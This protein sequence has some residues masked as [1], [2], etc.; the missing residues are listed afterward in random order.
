MPPSTPPDDMPFACL[1][2]YEVKGWLGGGRFGDVYL[3]LDPLTQREVAVKVVR[4]QGDATPYLEEVQNLAR[5]DHPAIV[6][7]Y[8]V[9][10]IK[11]RLLIV[12][13]VVKGESLREVLSKGRMEKGKTLETSTQLLEALDHAHERGVVH[14]DIKPE[15]IMI[16]PEVRV[17]VLDFGLS[18]LAQEDLSMSMGGTPAYMAPENWKG[19]FTPASDQWSAA[20]V[21][22]E[23]LTGINP[24]LGNTL[25]EAREKTIRGLR[26]ENLLSL[27]PQELAHAILRALSPKPEERYPSCRAFMEELLG[28]EK[29]GLTLVVRPLGKHKGLPPLTGEQ[30]Q[31]VEDPSPRILVTGGPGT[32]KT[33]LLLARAIRLLKEGEAPESI[34]LFTF[35]FRSWREMETRLEEAIGGDYRAIWLGNFYQ[36][37]LRIVSRFGHLFSL[38]TE[39]TLALPPQQERLVEEAAVKAGGEKAF[40]EI[41]KVYRRARVQGAPWV[42]MVSQA[43]GKWREMLEAFEEHYLRLVRE[44]NTLG[45]ED[46][47]YFALRLL[48]KEEV[49]SFYWERLRHVLVDEVQ[50][51]NG[52]QI[53]LVRVLAQGGSLFLVGD[54]DQSIYQWRG[55]QPSYLKEVKKQGFV[56]HG[57]TQT[58]RLPPEFREMAISLITKNRDRLPKLYWTYREEDKA[59]LFIQPLKTPREEAEYVADMIEILRMKRSYSYS[60]FAI[61]YR[62]K[63]RGRLMEQV[64]KKRKIPFTQEGGRAILDRE[65]VKALLDLLAFLARG[66]G[67]ILKKRVLK[68][69]SPLVGKREGALERLEGL[70]DTLDPNV[71]PSQALELGIEALNRF[72]FRIEAPLLVARMEAMEA[73]LKKAREFE[74]S[75]RSPTTAN[76]LR[77]IRFLKDAGLA[78]GEEGIRLLS[79]YGAKG[80]EFPVVFVVGLVEG[81]FPLTRVLGVPEEM[82]EERRLCYTAITRATEVLFL[83]YYRYPNPQSRFQER[84][85]PFIK[86]MLGVG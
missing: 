81:E 40:Q 30:R 59:M 84:P 73:L 54:D 38:P 78:G 65:E 18:R 60:D 45:Y 25:E 61:L 55:A 21:V 86:E 79:V 58:F 42:Q 64:L 44:R 29:G 56:H 62:V 43:T 31:A 4:F 83:T 75:A 76:F 39:F 9:D 26:E 52:A 77:Y 74:E 13:E 57:L 8:T 15:N 70:L 46:L 17:K 35:S 11:G 1:G 20:V 33:T 48:E 47:V 14:R 69:I 12:T 82:E 67:S 3:A 5:L 80:L 16:T 36:I 85:S 19:I 23:M 22:L 51:L 71:K 6:R 63:T 72:M 7:L 37:A 24:F 68:G 49:A 50:D 10:L 66:K 53:A 2:R 41:V 28:Y 27:L 34:A 32:G